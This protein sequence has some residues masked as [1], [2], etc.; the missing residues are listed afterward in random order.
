CICT[1]AQDCLKRAPPWPSSVDAA[2]CC[3][4]GCCCCC[5]LFFSQASCQ[6]RSSTSSTTRRRSCRSCRSCRS[7]CSCRNCPPYS[8]TVTRVLRGA[9]GLVSLPRSPEAGSRLVAF[10]CIAALSIGKYARIPLSR[11]LHLSRP[12]GGCLDICICRVRVA[13]VAPAPRALAA[14]QPTSSLVACHPG[15]HPLLHFRPASATSN[16]SPGLRPSPPT[17]P[18]ATLTFTRCKTRPQNHLAVSPEA[19]RVIQACDR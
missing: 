8:T 6:Q 18:V 14:C 17:M 15:A 9:C 1:V 3:G 5:P 19:H 11:H 7:F 12:S 2:I 16:I 10:S 4:L 13:A